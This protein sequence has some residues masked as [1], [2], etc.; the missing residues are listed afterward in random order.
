MPFD[1]F[2]QPHMHALRCPGDDAGAAEACIM[3]GGPTLEIH[4]IEG[5]SHLH[6]SGGI[7]AAQQGMIQ[8]V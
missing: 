8:K 2:R 7:K 5:S 6:W 3:T 1:D 4:T